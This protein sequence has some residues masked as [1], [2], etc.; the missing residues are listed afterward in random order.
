MLVIRV[1]NSFEL[2]IPN[3]TI[4][5]NLQV[6]DISDLKSRQCNYTNSFSI[7]KSRT[8]VYF[9]KQLGYV[10][11]VSNYPYEKV[12]VDLIENGVFLLRNGWLDFQETS[13][14]YKLNIRDGAID[15]FKAIENKTFGDDVDLSEINHQRNVGTVIGS[16]TNENYRYIINDYG[17]KT[18]LDNETKVNI[19]YLV[20]SVRYKYLWNKIFLT[21]GFNYIG[22]IFENTDFKD[23]WITYPKGIGDLDD[24]VELYAEL[25]KNFAGGVFFNE[26]LPFPTLNILKGSIDS[27]ALIKN[28]VYIIPETERYKIEAQIF[29]KGSDYYA[30]FGFFVFL[31]GARIGYWEYGEIA[32]LNLSLNA[33]DRIW[34]CPGTGGIDGFLARNY[35]VFSTTETPTATKS[36]L[37]ISKFNGTVSFS[38]ELKNLKITDFFKE[39]LNLFGLTIF[40]DK[41]NNYIFKTFNERLKADVI[42]WTDKYKERTSETYTPKSYG[43]RN[44]FT[45]KYNQEKESHSDGYFDISNKNI[46]EFKNVISSIFYSA[47]KEFVNFKLTP[48]HTEIVAPNLLWSKEVSENTGIQQIKYKELSNRF[49]LIRVKEVDVTTIFRS[50]FLDQENFANRIP[51]ANN[52]FTSYKDFVPKYYNNIKLLLEDFRLHKM[53]LNVNS[54]DIHNLDFDKIYYFEQEQNYYFLNKLSYKSVKITSADFYRVRKTI[55]EDVV[56]EMPTL[57]LIILIS[58]TLFQI[59]GSWISNVYLEYSTDGGSNYIR[60]PTTYTAS[61][62]LTTNEL[63][64]GLN[65]KVRLVP[66]CN[67]TLI[68]NVLNYEAVIIPTVYQFE[69]GY[70]SSSGPGGSIYVCDLPN[71]GSIFYSLDSVLVVGSKVYVDS[72]L[73]TPVFA[74]VFGFPAVWYKSGNK[75]YSFMGPIDGINQINECV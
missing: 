10:G 34:V 59:N 3:E 72:A 37:R 31:N 36:F 73:T 32:K 11:D 64:T 74:G 63:P 18:H 35:V 24:D 8:N 44:Y 23:L 6:N 20:P 66:V 28:A 51:I 75:V 61:D 29:S 9:F 52:F 58:P 41:D 17:G 50:E 16:F 13:K 55:A 15:I 14:E 7:P 60:V 57:S 2:E 1:N 46:D 43:Q 42:D 19:D 12:N 65:F 48:T 47:E 53:K 54:I 38:E 25:S 67:N 22:D 39:T 27:N 70:G 62:S 30:K 69:F 49:Q 4:T 33:G 45:Q 5:Y 40:V 71:T 21:F 26:Q 68:S 56:C